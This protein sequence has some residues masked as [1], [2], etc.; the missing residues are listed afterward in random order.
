MIREPLF[1]QNLWCCPSPSTN[2]SGSRVLSEEAE[3][4]LT[5]LKVAML[6]GV[7]ENGRG[8]LVLLKT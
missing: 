2:E 6:A 8:R 1:A 7:G 4:E 5:V 3:G